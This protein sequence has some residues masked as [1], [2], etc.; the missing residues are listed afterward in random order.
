MFIF[1]ALAL[2]TFV[3]L[4]EWRQVD[5]AVAQVDIVSQYPLGAFQLIHLTDV[6][7]AR[8]FCTVSITCCRAF[9]SWAVHIPGMFVMFPVR[10]LS[11]SFKQVISSIID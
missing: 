10:I 4:N 6:S 1:Y 11:I 2:D 9:L 7:D 8:M 5:Q 3:S